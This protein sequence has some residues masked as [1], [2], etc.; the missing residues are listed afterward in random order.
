MSFVPLRSPIKCHRANN[1]YG[2]YTASG[3]GKISTTYIIYGHW[4]V[5]TINAYF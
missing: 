1:T 3:K 5:L 2:R 4:F